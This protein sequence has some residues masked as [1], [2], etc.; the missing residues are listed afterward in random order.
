MIG[1]PQSALSAVC[2][3]CKKR[4]GSENLQWIME[5]IVRLLISSLLVSSVITSYQNLRSEELL[6]QP[7]A[8]P[9][10]HD[11]PLSVR[12]PTQDRH[13]QHSEGGDHEGHVHYWSRRLSEKSTECGWEDSWHRLGLL[14]GRVRRSEPV[15]EES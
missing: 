2:Q 4:G 3:S 7:L 13:D 9:A 11:H 14:K 15:T 5:L 12:I 6:S 10:D 8:P 1:L